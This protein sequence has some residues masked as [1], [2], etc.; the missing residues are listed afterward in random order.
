MTLMGVDEMGEDD[1]VADDATSSRRR[2]ATWRQPT[3]CI[4]PSVR[5]V[6]QEQRFG[7]TE[8]P[9]LSD[10][11]AE[12]V[13][14][15][16]RLP[17]VDLDLP[18][19]AT[20][21][22]GSPRNLKPSAAVAKANVS[23][24]ELLVLLDKPTAGGD[25][26]T[27]AQLNRR[28]RL[29]R[30]TTGGRDRTDITAQLHR[31]GFGHMFG[32]S[33][34]HL[35]DFN[36]MLGELA[37][38]YN[39]RVEPGRG[40]GLWDAD[41][42]TPRIRLEGEKKAEAAGGGSLSAR[43]PPIQKAGGAAGEYVM[44]SPRVSI[45][46]RTALLGS[47]LKVERGGV[48]RDIAEKFARLRADPRESAAFSDYVSTL[49]AQ[50]QRDASTSNRNLL[51]E[52]AASVFAAST[53]EA[54]TR[55]QAERVKKHTMRAEAAQARLHAQMKDERREHERLLT[56]HDEAVKRREALK[57]RAA[58]LRRQSA[59]LTLVALGATAARL[60]ATIEP[61]RELRHET[62]VAL[63]IQR[64]FRAR[65][66]RRRA[67]AIANSR[68][69]LTRVVWVLRLRLRA[70]LKR[71]AADKIRTMLRGASGQSRAMLAIR[72]YTYR[73]IKVQRFY[74]RVDAVTRAQMD[75]YVRQAKRAAQRRAL[76][77]LSDD[78]EEL[79]ATLAATDVNALSAAED[80]PFRYVPAAPMP[81]VEI[82]F[83]DGAIHEAVRTVLTQ[84]R[85]ER[86][87]L[88]P[89]Y[90]ER[91]KAYLPTPYLPFLLTADELDTVLHQAK[92]IDLARR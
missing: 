30:R 76:T 87:E 60:A 57:A 24:K 41:A 6:F 3:P 89:L 59:W 31:A 71:Q 42:S 70:A 90:R 78:P 83:S 73:V 92:M 22:L 33:D 49:V 35:N 79:A 2:V 64:T 55:R 61:S 27:A 44:K 18:R 91:R 7:K 46:E 54:A 43:P 39:D 12:L 8:L 4:S 77:E 82:A 72:A 50:R 5:K 51:R 17:C 88:R 14:M 74:R 19:L 26:P 20:P 62:E 48:A 1:A 15:K 29:G 63:R 84:R 10:R 66:L 68:R 47:A 11:T 65:V 13:G 75:L 40:S 58:L 28:N 69:A 81:P 80:N 25:P 37:R 56:K 38:L 21:D 16:S 36:S 85:R 34:D 9:L 53:R 23:T 86:A 32:G 67:R 45:L 52:N